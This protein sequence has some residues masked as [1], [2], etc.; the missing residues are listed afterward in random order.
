MALI[1]NIVSYWKFDESSGNAADSAGSNTL[2]NNGSMTYSAGVI[3]NG[4][5]DIVANSKY[6]SAADSASLTPSSSGFSWGFWIQVTSITGSQEVLC[7]VTGATYEYEIFM[8]GAGGLIMGL[9]Y[10]GDG[11]P[12][13]R[14]QFTTNAAALTAANTWTYIVITAIA[15]SNTVIFYVNG[16]SVASSTILSA[17]TAVADTAANF[18]IGIYDTGTPTAGMT[19]QIDEMGLWNRVLS[20]SEV[21]ELYNGGAGL[22]YPFAGVSAVG[23]GGRYLSLLGVGQ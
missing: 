7:K 5:T 11:T 2:T 8:S 10:S 4:A 14:S 22:Q 23:R 19:G 3:N 16:S 21:I 17:S 15:S 20:S 6:F 9:T 12:A 13:N 1:D 18:A